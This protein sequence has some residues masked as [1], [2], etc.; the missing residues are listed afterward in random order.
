MNKR[1]LFS[2]LGLVA[3]LIGG[4][5]FFGDSTF[6]KG[7]MAANP[8]AT[9]PDRTV[10]DAPQIRPTVKED[11]VTEK[12]V[13]PM[14][15]EDEK[16]EE[17]VNLKQFQQNL[18]KNPDSPVISSYEMGANWV[19]LY[20]PT[21]NYKLFQN[22]GAKY[23][24]VRVFNGNNERKDL[25]FVKEL[26]AIPMKDGKSVVEFKNLDNKFW[27]DFSAYF[28][29]GKQLWSEESNTM[30][31]LPQKMPTALKKIIAESPYTSFACGNYKLDDGE[32][33]I[34]LGWETPDSDEKITDVRVEY[35]NV[36]KKETSFQ[37]LNSKYLKCV[38]GTF[39]EIVGGKEKA[40]PKILLKQNE[41]YEFKLTPISFMGE[42]KY[43]GPSSSVIFSAK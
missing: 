2:F 18:Q 10:V 7:F 22:E 12:I 25:E 36:T 9:L 8:R 3:V 43:Y 20:I 21:P 33:Y 19:K 15:L 31:V 16:E 38:Y 17:A 5:Y 24:K 30:S 42:K 35:R 1:F 14:V 29:D 4:S 28:G 6:Y 34:R 13:N 32:V 37:E 27:Y 11:V 39:A 41:I 26:A 40:M 23:L